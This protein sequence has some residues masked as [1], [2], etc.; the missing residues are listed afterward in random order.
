MSHPELALPQSCTVRGW[1]SLNEFHG[2]V[3]PG[4]APEACTSDA[5]GIRRPALAITRCVVSRCTGNASWAFL[6]HQ[7]VCFSVPLRKK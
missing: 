1:E 2:P 6:N 3:T 5:L 4:M 7:W